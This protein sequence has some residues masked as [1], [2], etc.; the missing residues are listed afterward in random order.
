[1]R[2]E[3]DAD[4]GAKNLDHSINVTEA[5]MLF[6]IIFASPL[7]L[8]I[9]QKW[10]A[11]IINLMLYIAAWATI[12]F[13]GVGVIFWAFGVAHAIWHYRTQAQQEQA[14]AIAT[15]MI[16]AQETAKAVAAEMNKSQ[17]Q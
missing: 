17:T 8:A 2:S 4:H 1:M 13:F 7:Y 12:W 10:G 16:K 6:L 14:K 11:F 9:R 5:F 15:E 3:I